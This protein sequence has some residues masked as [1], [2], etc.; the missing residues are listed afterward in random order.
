M[1]PQITHFFKLFWGRIPTDPLRAR[2]CGARHF[3]PEALIRTPHP[4]PPP[5]KNPGYGPGDSVPD[6]RRRGH[7]LFTWILFGTWSQSWAGHV[8]SQDFRITFGWINT[9]TCC[10]PSPEIIQGLSVKKSTSSRVAIFLRT[11]ATKIRSV[12]GE[13][14]TCWL[15]GLASWGITPNKP[16]TN[17]SSWFE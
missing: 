10:S 17:D 11:K 8:V 1:R 13:Q 12:S 4:P 2:A 5:S 16:G 7:T 3:A 15:F 9:C 14:R 6:I